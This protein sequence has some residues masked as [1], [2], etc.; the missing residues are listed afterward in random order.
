MIQPRGSCNVTAAEADGDRHPVEGQSRFRNVNAQ[1]SGGEL[2]DS[3]P[4]FDSGLSLYPPSSRATVGD[5]VLRTG[6]GFGDP[7]RDL[8]ASAGLRHA[9]LG[10]GCRRDLRFVDGNRWG[11]G[12]T[13]WSG[14]ALASADRRGRP[15]LWL[16]GGRRSRLGSA[17]CRA[18]AAGAEPDASARHAF[19][20]LAR[21]RR[22]CAHAWTCAALL[23]SRAP[24]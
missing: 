18:D 12:H 10:G 21:R 15:V 6:F 1:Y 20:G 9:L 4:A 2:D 19:A 22:T 11:H 13:A 16:P 8:V 3:D 5:R 14:H 24:G 23:A 17:D 7:D